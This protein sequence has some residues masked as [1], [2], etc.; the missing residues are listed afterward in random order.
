MGSSDGEEC[1]YRA[2]GFRVVLSFCH[3][4]RLRSHLVQGRQPEGTAETEEFHVV[5]IYLTLDFCIGLAGHIRGRDNHHPS[6][7]RQRVG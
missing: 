5:R 1:A 2:L 7:L 6:S 4:E 3:H